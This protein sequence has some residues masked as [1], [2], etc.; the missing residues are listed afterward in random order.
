MFL[1]CNFH[2]RRLWR[3]TKYT[4]EGTFLTKNEGGCR[5]KEGGA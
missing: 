1:D 2:R 4:F 3:T 5:L